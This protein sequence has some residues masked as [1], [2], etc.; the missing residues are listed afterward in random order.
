MLKR[1][2]FSSRQILIKK[3]SYTV[4]NNINGKS[5]FDLVGNHSSFVKWLLPNAEK[6]ASKE[7]TMAKIAV[8]TSFWF[9]K[10]I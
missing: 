5:V 10:K 7:Y 2:K 8:F 9:E 3:P 4:V 6:S 1:T